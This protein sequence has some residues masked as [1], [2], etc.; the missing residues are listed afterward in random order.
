MIFGLFEGD[1]TPKYEE[2]TLS[3]E[4]IRA[5]QAAA[6]RALNSSPEAETQKLLEHTDRGAETL[7]N[8]G[9]VQEQQRHLGMLASDPEAQA[10]AARIHQRYNAD[11]NTLQRQAKLGGTPA[12]A[13]RLSQSAG[14]L[15]EK[16]KFD[17]NVYARKMQQYQNQLQARNGAISSILGVAGAVVGGIYGGPAGAAAGGYVGSAAG[18]SLAKSGQE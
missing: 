17:Q 7:P 5:Q 4:L 11:L 1:D 16:Q 9:I 6:N 8:S 13:N 14:A 10:I 3:P 12:Y 2:P 18:S 15:A